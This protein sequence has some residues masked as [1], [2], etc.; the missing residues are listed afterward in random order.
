MPLC[1]EILRAWDRTLGR[2]E[3]VS[4][5][6][7]VIRAGAICDGSG[8]A[9]FQ[10]DVAIHGDRIVA[11]GS[12]GTLEAEDEVDAR[13]LTVA[14]GF[15]NM[16]SHAQL[17]LI[18]DGRSQSDIRQG[19]TLEVMGES[20]V[21]PLNERMKR[22]RT[23]RQGDIKYAIQWSTLGEYL[24]WLV[25]HGVSCNVA[26]FLPAAMVRI[27]V[28]GYEDRPPAGNELDQMCELVRQ[29]MEQGAMGL[30]S[31]LIYTPA[32]FAATDEL[33]ALARVAA[34]Y[35]GR[36]ISHVRGEG[37][38]LME[39]V[40]EFLAI[41]GS[42]KVPAE[43]YHLKASGPENWHKLDAV[44]ERIGGVRTEGRD[45]SAN[46]YTYPAA[47]TGLDAAMPPW[48]QEGGH[49]EW[50]RRLRDPVIRERLKR[51]LTG[52]GG[53]WE[54]PLASLGGEGILLNSF[55]KEK[56]KPLTGK[57][58]AQVAEMRGTSPEETAMD[59]VVE[60]DSRVGA[61]YFSMSEEN[62][63]KKIRLP[64][65]SFGS[66]G[67]S[68]APEGVF[69][70]SQPHPRAYGTFARL[71]GKYVREERLVPLEEAVRRL[72]SF[73]A[74]NLKLDRRGLLREGYFADVVVFDPRTI[75]DH[76]T[77]E[78]PHQYATGVH[79]V[80]VN[81]VKVLHDGEHTG[82]TPGRFIPG[83]GYRQH[84]G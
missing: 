55:D 46:M 43:M 26:S 18:A 9:P 7:T 4:S 50:V 31:A 62:V 3:H 2:E 25:A 48:V 33:I 49:R 70:R 38:H 29:A 52:G 59:L 61:V 63:R 78:N 21:G 68:M 40:D 79:H 47:A 12:A 20:W 60:D 81:G 65:V 77:Y 30:S 34:A 39:A 36:Y 10:G 56:L 5:Y 17:S 37:T 28:L 41:A 16:L 44:I 19:V 35:G 6:D 64:W 72:T 1:T 24:E 84:G 82:A 76:A 14:P 80:W 75:R 57:T 22:E 13:G 45:V 8:T 73:P 11:I 67:G 71:L 15:I 66:D 69:L 58:L 23:E 51:E 27:Y 74:R 83:P 42:S 32:C 53:G 54:S